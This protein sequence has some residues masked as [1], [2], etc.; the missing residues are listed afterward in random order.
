M[1]QFLRMKIVL[2]YLIC[3]NILTLS[4]FGVDKLLAIKNKRR[5]PEKDLLAFSFVGGAIGGLLGMFMFNHKVSKG[6][7]L[8]KFTLV[9]ISQI[10][11]FVFMRI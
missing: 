10:V 2:L 8:W 3:I 9:L 1:P 6:S 5:I 7:F 11:L 4:L